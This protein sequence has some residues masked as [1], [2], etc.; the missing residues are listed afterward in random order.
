MF[1]NIFFVLI[2][3]FSLITVV[4]CKKDPKMSDERAAENVKN[5]GEQYP[6][7]SYSKDSAQVAAKLKMSGEEVTPEKIAEAL[8]KKRPADSNSSL[9]VVCELVKD[10]LVADEFDV[11]E[12]D[13]MVTNGK[14]RE[15][16]S[17]NSSSC[18]WRWSGGGIVI[19]VTQN[20]LPGE[21][22]NWTEKYITAKKSQGERS[23]ENGQTVKHNFS[24]FDGPGSDNLY[25]HNLGRYYSVYQD[26]YVVSVI[27]NN[28]MAE[29]KQKNIAK[30]I[31]NS[32]F[33]N[34]G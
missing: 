23:I 21:I 14:R 16:G 3:C 29:R 7:R 33:K 27:F 20:P 30:K 34:L 32:V 31:M 11:R 26:K 24:E 1:K 6:E 18:F 12:A 5:S 10:K 9:P 19:Q 8:T 28:N 22:P 17:N 15:T 4:S 13:I 25:N 2:L